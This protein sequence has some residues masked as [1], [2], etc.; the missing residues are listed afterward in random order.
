M[1]TLTV[2]QTNTAQHSNSR[3]LREFTTRR[4]SSGVNNVVSFEN[5]GNLPETCAQEA[6]EKEKVHEG[7]L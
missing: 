3:E 6:V 4:E 7:T 5:G 1:H 2:I